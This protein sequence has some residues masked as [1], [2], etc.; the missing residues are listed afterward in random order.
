[1]ETKGNRNRENSRSFD[2]KITV[3]FEVDILLSQEYERVLH[4]RLLSPEDHLMVAVLEDAVTDYKRY[5]GVDDKKGKKRFADAEAW[6]LD[7]GTDWVFSFVNC[8]EVLAV[9]PNYL[10]AG[11]LR[12]KEKNIARFSSARL[13]SGKQRSNNSLRKAA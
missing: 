12:W 8:C 3:L 10:R 7:D 5:G 1:M 6:I 11:L 4:K 9:E 13:L 2:E